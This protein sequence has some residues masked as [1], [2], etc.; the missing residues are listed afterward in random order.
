MTS[1][2]LLTHSASAPA[3]TSSSANSGP[4]HHASNSLPRWRPRRPRL[5]AGHRGRQGRHSLRP[6]AGDAGDVIG[7]PTHIYLAPL[8]AQFDRNQARLAGVLAAPVYDSA[9]AA[10]VADDPWFARP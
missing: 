4:G 8:E 6:V 5:P 9:T 2:T 10:T 3:S 7:R 1:P